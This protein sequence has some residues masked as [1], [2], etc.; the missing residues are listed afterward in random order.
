M[1]SERQGAVPF[2]QEEKDPLAMEEPEASQDSL[3]C[4]SVS[5]N[6][7]IALNIPMEDILGSSPDKAV[8]NFE[9]DTHIEKS[10]IKQEC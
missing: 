9:K 5:D 3:S 10:S 8:V 2:A 7:V 6:N 1:L 4:Q